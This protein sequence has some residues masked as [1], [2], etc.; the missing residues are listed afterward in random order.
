MLE[1]ERMGSKITSAFLI[2]FLLAS[3]V[4][5]M[6]G[7]S[8]AAVAS[9]ASDWWNSS[10][11]YR[12]PINVTNGGSSALTD[13][14]ILI[15]VDTA[16]L[17]SA[18]KMRSDAGDLRFRTPD[19]ENLPYWIESGANTASTKVWVKVPTVSA[20][21]TATI[22]MY[23]GNPDATSTAS[24]DAVFEFFDDF[25]DGVWTDKWQAMSGTPS[26]SGGVMTLTPRTWAESKFTVP[27][28]TATCT[29]L[30][31]DSST[32]T[33]SQIFVT[34]QMGW[35][36]LAPGGCWYH[37]YS[38]ATRE[39]GFGLTYWHTANI[40]TITLHESNSPDYTEVNRNEVSGW[41]PPYYHVTG[42][43]DVE[44]AW[45]AG[46][47]VFKAP[48]GTATHTTN[49][50]SASRTPKVQLSEDT[51]YDVVYVR[52][53]AS[54]EPTAVTGTEETQVPAIVPATVN[55]D[56]NTL[57]LKS[58]GK[59]ITAYIELPS[60]YNVSNIDVGTVR[61]NG[62]VAAQL[63]PA[64]VGDHDADGVQDLMVKFDRSAVQALVARGLV[65]LTVTGKV[66]TLDF[67]GSD[68]IRVI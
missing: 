9:G 23:Y 50:P 38:T 3:T 51:K 42:W 45:T 37:D 57:N 52:K 1:V 59:W 55:I 66:G 24:G 2:S 20:S 64:A 26:E 33:A 35:Y 27:I 32:Y 48:E 60:G 54:P 61:L 29:R 6:A 11:Q 13:Y 62:S 15:V 40:Y 65:E 28:N 4:S 16:S 53:Y 44:M 7:L 39:V 43:K 58:N 5:V 56:P 34:E 19:G 36:S 18:G 63:Q 8:S 17:V 12:K 67:E 41:A 47:V 22:Y 46:K 30:Y 49:V 21:G 31:T 10:W 14:Q 25:N 68:T